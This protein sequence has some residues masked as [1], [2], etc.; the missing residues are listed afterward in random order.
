MVSHPLD[1]DATTPALLLQLL[2]QV[3]S[4]KTSVDIMSR[5]QRKKG[6]GLGWHAQG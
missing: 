1:D 6:K 2:L 5:T 3:E 4:Q